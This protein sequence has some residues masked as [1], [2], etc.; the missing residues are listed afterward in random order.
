MDVS[1]WIIPVNTPL[2]NAVRNIN[3]IVGCVFQTCL[4][5]HRRQ[6]IVDERASGGKQKTRG[7]LM[8]KEYE[9]NAVINIP[10]VNGRTNPAI[11]LSTFIS[12]L[13]FAKVAIIFITLQGYT[14]KIYKIIIS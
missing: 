1:D 12:R 9:K 11:S 5:R 8:N 6:I 14:D 13:F 4:S 7:F 10:A 2:K 3:M